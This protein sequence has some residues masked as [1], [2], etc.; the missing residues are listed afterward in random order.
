MVSAGDATTHFFEELRKRQHEPRLRGATGTYRFELVD[1]KKIDRWLVT[2]SKGDVTVSRRGGA[3]DCVVRADRAL[4]NRL[5]SGE[6]NG[7]RQRFVVSSK[8]RATGGCSF[9]FSVCFRGRL[10]ERRQAVPCRLCAEDGMN[11]GLVKILDGNT[12]VVSDANGDIEASLTD[13]TGL[14][15]FDTR[16]SRGGC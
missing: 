1:G 6:L 4:F 7:L 11:D 14:F 9:S 16:F 12:F 5:A 3:A 13:P 15:S 2:F 8:P 10:S